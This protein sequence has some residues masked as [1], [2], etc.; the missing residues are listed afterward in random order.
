MAYNIVVPDA[1]WS[2]QS[3]TLGG[4]SFI[5]ELK[6]KARTD[7]WYITLKDSNGN[8]LITEKKIVDQQ[9]MTGLF[10]IEGMYGD[11]FCERV[12]GTDI[13]PTRQTLGIDKQF[14]LMY[15]TEE[16]MNWVLRLNGNDKVLG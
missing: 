8:D 3:I 12:Y 5:L 14:N 15:M 7:R 11:I 13:Y 6:F 4:T 10:D 1:D 9:T 2:S 16:E